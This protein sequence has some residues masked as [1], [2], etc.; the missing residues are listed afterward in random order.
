[1][2]A[3]ASVHPAFAQYPGEPAIPD[4]TYDP[5]REMNYDRQW[6]TPDETVRQV[7]QVLRDQGYYHGPLAACATRNT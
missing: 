2:L 3:S 6:G 1:L 4:R 7:Q 5:V